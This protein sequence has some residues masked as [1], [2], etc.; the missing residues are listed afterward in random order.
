MCGQHKLGSAECEPCKKNSMILQR[1]PR[2]S[3]EPAGVPSLVPDVVRSLGQTLDRDTQ[4]FFEA[5]FDRDF[6]QAPGI[7]NDIL[8]MPYRPTMAA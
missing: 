6:S 5:C 7:W 2:A 1:Y 4:A 8:E 3:A